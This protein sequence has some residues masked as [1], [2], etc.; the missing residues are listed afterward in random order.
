MTVGILGL[1]L[2]APLAGWAADGY[3][4]RVEQVL[5][6]TPLIDGHND[7]PW[8]IRD[9]FKSDLAAVD[10][11]A[12]TQHLPYPPDGAPLMTDIPRM[13]AGLM[14]GQFWSV[15]IPSGM[16]GPEAVQTTLEQMDLVKRMAA[17]YSGDFEMAY[18]AADVR[19]IHQS[20]RIAAMIGIEGGHQINNSLAALRQMY[21]AGA[22]YMTL[23]HT[24]NTGW[25]DSATDTP[26]HHGLT[27][28]GIEVV[29]EMNRLGM[30]V[31]LSH[32][33]SETMKAAL[34]ASEAP[35]IFSHSSA[36]AVVDHPRNVP[37]DVLR[38]VAANGGVVMVN[39]APGYVSDARYHW[40]A[41]EAAERARFN[42]P[43]YIGLYIGQPERAKAAL[44]AWTEKHPRPTAT[45]A[46]VADHAEHIRQVAG[47][48]H[49]GLG[50]DFDGIGDA[51][52]GLDGVDKYPALLEELM[53]RGW[54]DADIAKIAGENVLRV[55]AAAEKV[56]VKLRASRPAS[57]LVFVEAKDH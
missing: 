39:F 12:D 5:L 36:R 48:D 54:T 51:P 7:L 56:A 53:R 25:A 23:T 49:V 29:R 50:S 42:N 2:S 10:L 19:R 15:W 44:A 24:L 32:V 35:V 27:P 6:S 18:T 22:R 20:H 33:S 16:K 17:R 57:S 52:V 31:D 46:Q 45:L 14:G 55:M 40:D 43:P 21:D 41:D 3:H 11:K 8:E 37:D 26:V 28:F 30:L 1:L 4:H 34:A 13:R 38:S 9:R 47:I